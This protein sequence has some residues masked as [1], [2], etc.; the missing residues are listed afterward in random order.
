MQWST[1]KN[2]GFSDAASERLYLP[3]DPNPGAP[4][5]EAQEKD[6]RSLLNTV[7]A[8]FR[9][10][11]AEPD[12][13]GRPN[14]EILFAERGR[15]PFVY[16]RGAF[17]M[18]VNPGGAPA[19]AEIQGQGDLVYAIGGCSLEGGRCRMDGQSFGLWKT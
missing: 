17:V 6:P 9:L 5:V 1:G 2:L 18:A 19:E 7:K 15:L 13:G 3:V 12:L 16:R 4:T 14:L 10:R 8:L 11:R